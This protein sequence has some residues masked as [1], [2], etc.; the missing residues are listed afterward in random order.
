M[1]NAHFE[2]GKYFFGGAK[3]EPQQSTKWYNTTTY[4]WHGSRGGSA[5]SPAF[6]WLSGP[7]LVQRFLEVP[8]QFGDDHFVGYSRK[9]VTLDFLNAKSQFGDCQNVCYS[10]KSVISESG[11]S[12]NLCI[13]KGKAENKME[14]SLAWIQM[15]YFYLCS[16]KKGPFSSSKCTLKEKL[17]TASPS[18]IVSVPTIFVFPFFDDGRNQKKTKVTKNFLDFYIFRSAV[19]NGRPKEER[20]F[21]ILCCFYEY[22][23]R[24]VL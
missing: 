13:W 6:Q 19:N 1:W 5:I 7:L 15:A 23:S 11:T 9:S 18:R 3:K 20:N 17:F 2:G 4:T 21:L 8:D 24:N 16:Q 12:E 14:F 22:N 10:R